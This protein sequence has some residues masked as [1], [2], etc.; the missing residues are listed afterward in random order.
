LSEIK[1]NTGTFKSFDGTSIYYE[2]RGEGRPVVLAYGLGC[3]MNHWTHQVKYFSQEYQT[4]LLDYRGHHRS[5][6]PEN[7]ENLTL[8]AIAEDI[9]L[10]L[11]HLGL[12][13]ASFW[14]HSYGVQILLRTFDLYPKL[15]HDFVFINGFASN[16]IKGMFGV[17]TVATVFELF[18]EGYQNFPEAL[19]WLWKNSVRNPLAIP[20]SA[21]AGG[22]NL[23]LTSLKDIE[24]YAKG[25]AAMDLNVFIKLFEQ[26]MAYDGS[27]VLDK[28]D[29]PTL[30]ISGTKDGVTPMSHQERMQARI[31]GSQLQRVPYG[32]H[33]TQLDMPD[34]VNL[35]IEKFLK[36]IGWS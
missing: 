31:R 21:L 20:L 14:G 11:K 33:C 27:P 24:V 4:I 17:D 29:I 10:L 23:Q 19:T 18:K 35:R 16:P 13:K 12:R 9:H 8:D 32:S 26:M 15:F 25:V 22:F 34:F 1:K 28:I 2:V 6:A 7:L 5:G 36:E 3:V 30:I